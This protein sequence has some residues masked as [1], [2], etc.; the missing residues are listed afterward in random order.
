LSNRKHFAKIENVQSGLVSISN[1]VPQGSVLGPLFFMCT[2]M[3]YLNPLNFILCYMLMIL[4]FVYLVKIWAICSTWQ[5][6][7]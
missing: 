2:V 6:W 5:I 1:G 7:N 3:I 4:L